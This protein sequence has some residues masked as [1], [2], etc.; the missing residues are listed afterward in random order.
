MCAQA[1][2]RG[3]T[4]IFYKHHE[5]RKSM[6]TNLSIIIN[7]FAYAVW[8]LDEWTTGAGHQ[9]DLRAIAETHS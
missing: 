9:G 1:I 7:I 8:R 3:H 6:K 2:F 4:N 5:Q